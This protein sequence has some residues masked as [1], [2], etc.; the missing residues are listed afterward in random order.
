M[1]PLN[2]SA[3]SAP[4]GDVFVDVLAL[5]DLPVGGQHVAQLGLRRVLICRT[6]DDVLHAISDVCPH[7]LQPLA[8]GEVADGAIRCPK[9]GARFELCSGKPLNAVSKTALPVHAVRIRDG[10]VEVSS[11]PQR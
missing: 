8:G 7:A 3:G 10:R 9:H 4:A 11:L 2:P 6:A 1:F 5:A